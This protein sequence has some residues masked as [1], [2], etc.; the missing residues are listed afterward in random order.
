MRRRRSRSE[1]QR[2]VTE[3][4]RS[5]L[6]VAEFCAQHELRGRRFGWWRWKLRQVPAGALPSRGA[7][8]IRLLPV[9]VVPALGRAE[10]DVL[11]RVSGIEIRVTVGTDVGYVAALAA[12]LRSRC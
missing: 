1:W 9:D 4:E 8:D 10:P 6:S 2:L 7:A 12:E 3:F 11:V 5:D